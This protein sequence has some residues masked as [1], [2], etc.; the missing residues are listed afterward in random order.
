MPIARPEP[1]TEG[2]STSEFD[3]GKPPLTEWLRVWALKNQ[4]K[5]ARTFVIAERGA[6]VSHYALT[7]GAVYHEGAPA[8]LRRNMPDPVPIMLMGRLAVDLRWQRRGIGQAMMRDV[9]IRIANVNKDAGFA[10]L[11]V[12]AIDDEAVGFYLKFGMRLFPDRSR[13][14]FLPIATIARELQGPKSFTGLRRY[15]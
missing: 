1:L 8:A 9:F 6:V 11:L 12:H 10:A 3:C 7:T 5:S 13:T 14:L 4:G 15:G 2:H